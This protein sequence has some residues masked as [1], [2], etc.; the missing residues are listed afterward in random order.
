V[1]GMPVVA[2]TADREAARE[3]ARSTVANSLTMPWYAAIIAQLGYG[4]Q[5]AGAVNDE[6]VDTVVGHGDAGSIAALAAAHRA[7]GADHVI[8]MS[9]GGGSADLMTG[10]GQLESLA[11]A[12]LEVR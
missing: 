3:K 5:Q 12:V 7:A 8:L 4:E 1:V 6:F 2:D 9:S 10:T 11:P